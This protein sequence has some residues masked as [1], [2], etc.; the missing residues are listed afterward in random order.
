MVLSL[1]VILGGT[2]GFFLG[3]T[4]ALAIVYFCFSKKENKEEKNI[5]QTEESPLYEKI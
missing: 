1:Q 4:C 5:T 2:C 3:T